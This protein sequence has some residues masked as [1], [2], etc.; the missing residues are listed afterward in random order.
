MD[1]ALLKYQRRT[2]KLM[3][4]K[5]IVL[6]QTDRG[7]YP[8]LTAPNLTQK[9]LGQL[10]RRRIEPVFATRQRV[11]GVALDQFGMG[12]RIGALAG[13]ERLIRPAGH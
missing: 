13:N 9:C 12:S 11:N 2:D 3:P 10:K 6:A 8:F 5:A 4:L 1:D 7:K